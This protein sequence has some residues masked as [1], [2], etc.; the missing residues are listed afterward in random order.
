MNEGFIGRDA[1]YFDPESE[2]VAYDGKLAH[3]NN[4]LFRERFEK[5]LAVVS[6]MDGSRPLAR[7]RGM[8]Q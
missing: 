7:Y 2:T 5:Y 3:V 6:P 1:P 4:Y 8:T